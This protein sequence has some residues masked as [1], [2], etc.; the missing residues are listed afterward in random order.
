MKRDLDLMRNILITAEDSDGAVGF[1]TLLECESDAEKLA[2]HVEL[3]QSRGLV[4]ATVRRD[5]IRRC[6]IDAEVLAVTWEGYDCLDAIRSP[7]VWE[8]AKEAVSK[9]VGE[10]SLSVMKDT[11]QAVARG[12]IMNHLGMQ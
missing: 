10:T 11:C 5:G 6:P 4:S 3:M 9:A 7:K 2:Y 12:M 1:G 8:K